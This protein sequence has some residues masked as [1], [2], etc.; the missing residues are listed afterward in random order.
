MFQLSKVSGD[1]VDK[2][3]FNPESKGV[4]AKGIPGKA[5]GVPAYTEE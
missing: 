1:D 5:A 4:H 3:F 2:Q